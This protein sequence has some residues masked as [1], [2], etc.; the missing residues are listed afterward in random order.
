[1]ETFSISQGVRLH[2]SVKSTLVEWGAERF[3]GTVEIGGEKLVG[4]HDEVGNDNT[5]ALGFFA[6]G[7]VSKKSRSLS[8][9]A[10]YFRRT[11]RKR[12]YY[13]KRYLSK[14]DSA[15][16]AGNFNTKALKPAEWRAELGL[17]GIVELDLGKNTTTGA[18]SLQDVHSI[19]SSNFNT[20]VLNNLKRA[21]TSRTFKPYQPLS[22]SELP[23]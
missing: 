21:P 16:N 10:L 1:M 20:I 22:V 17:L 12:S 23:V 15:L 18:Q 4:C 7:G 19:I 11:A 9:S 3:G 14:Y 2:E 13:N 8:S 5:C 6:N